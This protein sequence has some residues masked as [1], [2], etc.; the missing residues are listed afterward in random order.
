MKSMNPRVRKFLVSSCVLTAGLVIGF[1]VPRP[2]WAEGFFARF[3][4]SHDSEGTS[5]PSATPPLEP[6]TTPA[7]DGAES[8]ELKELRAAETALFPELPTTPQPVTRVRA[9]ARQCGPGDPSKACQKDEPPTDP[10]EGA[11][12]EWMVGLRM[13]E[14]PIRADSR[15]ERFVRYF[16]QNTQGRKLFRSW[17]KRSGRYRTNVATILQQEGLTQDLHAL[18]MVESGYSPTAVSTAG[19][20]GLWQLMPET[21]RIYGLAVEDDYDER[22]NVEK[23]T[24]VAAKHIRDLYAKFGSW[25]LTFAAYDMGYKGLLGRVRDLS[26]NDFWTMATI[27]GALPREALLYV[28]KV[29]AVALILKNL[30]RYGFDD[31]HIDAPVSFADL[32]VPSGTELGTVAR[33]AGTSLQFLRQLNPEMLKDVVPDRGSRFDVHIPSTST[34]RASA[35]LTH[36]LNQRDRDR[37][38]AP[39]DF[40]WGTDE[41]PP[42][43]QRTARRALDLDDDVV[44]PAPAS[45]NRRSHAR[46]AVDDDDSA[47]ALPAWSRKRASRD[48][49]DVGVERDVVLYRVGENETVLSIARSFNVRA[50]D[51]IDDNH[52]NPA[53]RL[54]R[55]MVLKLRPPAS[56]VQR[57]ESKR[58]QARL[59]AQ[60]EEDSGARIREP[61]FRGRNQDDEPS[62]VRALKR[63][64]KA[65]RDDDTRSAS[66]DF[67][68]LQGAGDAGVG[69]ARQHADDGEML[70]AF[71]IALSEPRHKRATVHLNRLR[72]SHSDA[73][74]HPRKTQKRTDDP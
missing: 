68:D 11:E 18:V 54:Q 49:D 57:I 63:R 7:R 19:A 51:I 53:S 13:P 34:M 9:G 55:G 2:G 62:T 60:D 4:G 30:D 64:D 20:A 33:A 65:G 17:L 50:D 5:A 32:A 25:D 15:V 8:T 44:D 58:A 66:L 46:A 1:G 21:A 69:A 36:L 52:L 41:A 59:D 31:T 47:D 42:P 3:S 56:A 12:A 24:K 6:L 73:G 26:S 61:E 48:D 67:G 23:S 27:D 40:D 74:L 72:P 28:P 22:R 45:R 10:A 16:T 71:A 29:L 38:D 37:S 14:I 70:D 39:S 43:R 35:L